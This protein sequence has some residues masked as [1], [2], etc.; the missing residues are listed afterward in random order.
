M[1]GESMQ[2]VRRPL[3]QSTLWN[4][5]A[6]ALSS[7]NNRRTSCQQGQKGRQ[8]FHRSPSSQFHLHNAG[9]LLCAFCRLLKSLH[10]L[11]GHTT[12][13]CKRQCISVCP[14]VFLG[15]LVKKKF[16][17]VV[18][19]YLQL[20]FFRAFFFCREDRTVT[21]IVCTLLRKTRGVVTLDCRLFFQST[22]LFFT[23]FCFV[24]SPS[25]EA[26]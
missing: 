4:D 13:L 16:R 19:T 20:L 8:G 5:T 6:R 2:S 3:T 17:V 25:R 12:S 23:D 22:S 7:H 21:Q 15:W 18:W 24:T 11:L 14:T 9:L 1:S 26:S 10:G